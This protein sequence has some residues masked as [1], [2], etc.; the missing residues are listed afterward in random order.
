MSQVNMFF[1]SFTIKVDQ[2]ASGRDKEGGRI[3]VEARLSG[4]LLGTWSKS[5]DF[6]F[7]IDT[8]SNFRFF[9]ILDTFIIIGPIIKDIHGG[10]AMH[11]FGYGHLADIFGMTKERLTGCW[12]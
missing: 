5:H 7:L 8:E 6:I 12:F 3:L 1:C 4:M 9:L 11:N 2:L 10:V